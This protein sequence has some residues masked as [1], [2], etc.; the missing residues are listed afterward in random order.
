MA[1]EKR[2]VVKI[3]VNRR[4]AEGNGLTRQMDKAVS[5]WSKLDYWLWQRDA[6][7]RI[8]HNKEVGK[9]VLSLVR[10][11]GISRDVVPHVWSRIN[12]RIADEL[13]TTGTGRQSVPETN[14]AKRNRP[15]EMTPCRVEWY[16]DK[17]VFR[18]QYRLAEQIL[19]IARR[20]K[21]GGETPA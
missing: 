19:Q 11:S 3:A 5:R 17:L 10:E 16:F 4:T 2:P 20:A 15:N 9:V 13:R 12:E 6:F 21:P 14:R 1:V 18:R 7:D 8:R